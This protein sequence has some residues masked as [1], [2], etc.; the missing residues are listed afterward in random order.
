MQQEWKDTPT[1]NRVKLEPVNYTPQE[2]TNVPGLL[3][4]IGFVVLF[5]ILY[6]GITAF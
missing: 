5:V 3:L 2:W 1:K 6:I 4:L